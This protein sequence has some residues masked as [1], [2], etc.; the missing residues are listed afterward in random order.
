MWFLKVYLKY[1]DFLIFQ[2]SPWRSDT[3]TSLNESAAGM[4]ASQLIDDGDER[5][6]EERRQRHDHPHA[7]QPAHAAQVFDQP[8]RLEV[9]VSKAF[10]KD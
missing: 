1:N 3:N 5:R 4:P 10:W 9:A 8:D 6:G 2:E 7:R